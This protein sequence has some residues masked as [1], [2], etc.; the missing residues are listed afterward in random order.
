[1]KTDMARRISAL[2]LKAGL[3]HDGVDVIIRTFVSPGPHGPQESDCKALCSPC[4]WQVDREPGE[5]RDAF[6]QRASGIAPRGAGGLAV[7]RE[8]L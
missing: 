2:E 8:V 4:G 6:I 1:M 3:G 7:L 5:A